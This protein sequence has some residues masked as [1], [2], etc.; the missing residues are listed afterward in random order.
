MGSTHR[1]VARRGRPEETDERRKHQTPCTLHEPNVGAGY[2]AVG[3]GPSL[4]R[5]VGN[6][7]ATGTLRRK[8]LLLL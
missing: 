7:S 1:E 4:I 2:R 8:Q 6:R 3:Y 5:V